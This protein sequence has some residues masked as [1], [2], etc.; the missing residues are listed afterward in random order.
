MSEI[1]GVSFLLPTIFKV[2]FVKDFNHFLIN[3]LGSKS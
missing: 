3:I 1:E 2:G